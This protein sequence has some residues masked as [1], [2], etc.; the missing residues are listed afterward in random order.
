VSP[1]LREAAQE[2]R[3]V[4][5]G[6]RSFRGPRRAP[7]SRLRAPWVDPPAVDGMR[8]GQELPLDMSALRSQRTSV[9]LSTLTMPVLARSCVKTTRI[10]AQWTRRP[11]G[12]EGR[13]SSLSLARLWPAA[14]AGKAGPG[15]SKLACC[16]VTTT[17]RSCSSEISTP[18]PFC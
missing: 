15:L 9:G 18:P 17:K 5:A 10:L 12:T 4:Q 7:R 6:R 11:P 2:R 14:P 8:G 13:S 16:S 3:T 1:L